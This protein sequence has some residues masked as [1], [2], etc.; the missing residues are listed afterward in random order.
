[1]L[2]AP[3]GLRRLADVHEER[4]RGVA[5]EGTWTSAVRAGELTPSQS[6]TDS[7]GA[8]EAGR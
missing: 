7:I 2:A 8:L 5:S 4:R 3:T 1:M 6:L